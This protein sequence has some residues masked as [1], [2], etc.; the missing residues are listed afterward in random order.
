MN[1]GT[2]SPALVAARLNALLVHCGL[3]AAASNAIICDGP[4][5]GCRPA[6]GE[7]AAVALSAVASAAALLWQMRGGSAQSV[8]ISTLQAAATLRSYTLQTLDGLSPG[9]APSDATPLAQFYRTRDDRQFFI[10]GVLPHLAEGTLRVLGLGEPGFS[11]IAQAVATWDALAL[12]DA[13]AAAGMCGAY[14]RSA[15]EWNAHPQQQATAAAG[16]LEILRI[17]DAPPEPLPHGLSPGVRPL[18][19]IRVLDLTRILAGPTCGRTLAEHGAEVLLISAPKLASVK[20]FVLDTGPGKRSAYLD[21][22]VPADLATLQTLITG[23][24]V[25]SQSFRTG[26]L[27]RRGLAPAALAAARPGIVCVSINCYGHQGP[28]AGRPGWDQLAAAATGLAQMQGEPEGLPRLLNCAACDYVTGYLAALGVLT[29]LQRRV[30]EGGSWEVRV[31]LAQTG[32]WLR[33]FAVPHSIGTSVDLSVPSSYFMESDT[34]LGRLRH[35]APVVRMSETP[36]H[37][38]LPAV[39]LG[40]HPAA[41][42]ASAGSGTVFSPHRQFS[43]QGAP[44]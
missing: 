24:D 43:Q 34:P 18:S 25:F 6:V 11:E 3:P 5:P 12:E 31:S 30:T 2:A 19:G 41:W 32:R 39:P 29:A 44:A 16:P 14:A 23:T 8:S 15:A 17:G 26:R 40:Y 37:W 38:A 22:D 9:G 13:L 4:A 20:A 27:A 42:A 36:P 1:A 10:H 21:L 33:N 35:L 28:W 7:A